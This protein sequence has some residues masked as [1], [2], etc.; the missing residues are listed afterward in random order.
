MSQR[1][2]RKKDHIDLANKYYL[3]HPDADFSGINLIRPALP[4]SKIYSDSIK[5][6]FSIRL[7]VHHSLLKP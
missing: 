3:P 5:T 6:T 1:S 7:L 4:E 2:Q